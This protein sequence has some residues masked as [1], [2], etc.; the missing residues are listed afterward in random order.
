[1]PEQF[2][3]KVITA[4]SGSYRLMRLSDVKNVFAI[5]KDIY[6]F[7]WTEGIF[8][9]CINAGQLCIVNEI[10]NKIVSYGVVG[11]IVNEAHILN[12][13]VRR[14]MQGKRY[15]RELLVYLLDLVQRSGAERALLEVRES[16]QIAL[17]LYQSMGFEEIGVR[18]DYYPAEGGRENAIVLAKA[19]LS[20]IN[21]KP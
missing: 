14:D 10:E 3:P 1:M 15:G 2:L 17:S 18:K 20:N 8:T 11:M 16:N 6:P 21:I 12:L 19:I 5:D 9:D 7:P 13:S 4:I